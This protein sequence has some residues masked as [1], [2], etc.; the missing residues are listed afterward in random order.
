M[1]AHGS[2]NLSER[3]RTKT[4]C[5]DIDET[6]EVCNSTTKTCQI[7][8]TISLALGTAAITVSPFTT[9][10]SEYSAFICFA[11]GFTLKMGADIGDEIIGK[12]TVNQRLRKM[13]NNLLDWGHGKARDHAQQDDGY[14]NGLHNLSDA[15]L[16]DNIKNNFEKIHQL[17]GGK[18]LD[19]WKILFKILSERHSPIIMFIILLR[20]SFSLISNGADLAEQNAAEAHIPKIN[21]DLAMALGVIIGI[22][23]LIFMIDIISLTLRHEKMQELMKLQK[24]VLEHIACISCIGEI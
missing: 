1:M 3:M 7:V 9:L 5:D 18:N 6:I 20:L 14:I 10:V 2:E 17:A 11:F 8:G 13:Y 23:I 12:K 15:I 24:N 16:M 4:D 19:N 22:G 21:L